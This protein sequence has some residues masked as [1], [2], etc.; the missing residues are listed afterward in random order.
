MHKISFPATKSDMDLVSQLFELLNKYASLLEATSTTVLRT[1]N[2]HGH[3]YCKAC[4]VIEGALAELGR[5]ERE[6]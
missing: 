1:I 2:E 4:A 3:P 6:A 5:V